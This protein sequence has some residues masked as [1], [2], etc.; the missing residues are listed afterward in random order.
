MVDYDDGSPSLN[1]FLFPFW[2]NQDRQKEWTVIML[3]SEQ[4]LQE[5][6]CDRKA[7]RVNRKSV[8][9]PRKNWMLTTKEM[10]NRERVYESN[11]NVMSFI[12][13][14]HRHSSSSLKNQQEEGMN[15]WSIDCYH[16]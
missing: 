1:H 2:N 12:L 13:L 11:V 14:T 10:V 6:S 5:M 4:V 16:E 8:T 7:I 9:T 3:R 15:G